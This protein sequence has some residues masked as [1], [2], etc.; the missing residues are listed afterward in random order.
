MKYALLSIPL[1][2]GTSCMNS[3]SDSSLYF[4]EID[5]QKISKIHIEG[6]FDR[7]DP[8]LGSSRSDVVKIC[9]ALQATKR[10]I[11]AP[12]GPGFYL[13]FYKGD[14][15][16][17]VIWIRDSGQWG[18]FGAERLH[19]LGESQEILD[20]INQYIEKPKKPEIIEKLPKKLKDGS[21][22]EL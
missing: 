1:L 2:L 12:D 13:T 8:K 6:A 19:I 16:S 4:S 17:H 18:I 9:K 21:A 11:P 10:V 22:V 7:V 3:S 15:V 5:V 14:D 20:L